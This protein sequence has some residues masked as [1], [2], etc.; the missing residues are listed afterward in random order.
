MARYRTYCPSIFGIIIIIG[1]FIAAVAGQRQGFENVKIQ[2]R[3]VDH[4]WSKYDPDLHPHASS[5]DILRHL[6]TPEIRAAHEK[7]IRH[8]I[9]SKEERDQ[10]RGLEKHT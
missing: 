2:G 4:S 5:K 8:V 3:S 1:P 7:R 9:M 6:P 10:E